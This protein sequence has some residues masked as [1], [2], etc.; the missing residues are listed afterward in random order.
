MRCHRTKRS[1]ANSERQKVVIVALYFYLRQNMF[2]FLDEGFKFLDRSSRHLQPLYA[3][4]SADRLQ[5]VCSVALLGKP[6][7]GVQGISKKAISIA[8]RLA[9]RHGC[10]FLENPSDVACGGYVDVDLLGDT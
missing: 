8:Q 6:S 5:D 1:Q 3:S 2:E 7:S 10:G 9:L 4:S